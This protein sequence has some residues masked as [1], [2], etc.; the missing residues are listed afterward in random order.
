[1][2][3]VKLAAGFLVA[4]V[5]VSNAAV[6][7]QPAA[8]AA[9]AATGKVVNAASCSQADVQKATDSASDG[10]SVV[11]P[12][13]SG[14]W[15]TPVIIANKGITLR[16]AGINKTVITA[17]TGHQQCPL[18]VA[19]VEGKPLRITGFTFNGTRS[20]G[21]TINLRGTCK[22]FRVDHC[23]ISN[24]PSQ[25][26]N[27]RG[28][29]AGGYSYGVIDH[30]VIVVPEPGGAPY[31][32]V[33]FVGDGDAAWERPITLGTA[34]AAYV[35]DC[36]FYY[37][38]SFADG[39]LDAYGG[40]RYVFRHNTVINTMVGHHGLDSGGYR[41]PHSF[42]YYENTFI[43]DP[44]IYHWATFHFRGGTGVVFNNTMTGY[45]AAILVTNYRSMRSYDPWGK[46]DGKNPIDGNEDPSGYP[47][48]DQIGRTTGQK[49]DPLC[50]WNN[51]LGGKHM[52]IGL[53]MGG[54]DHPELLQHIKE[55]RDYYNNTVKPGY[56]PYAYPHPLTLEPAERAQA[57]EPSPAPTLDTKPE[58]TAA[59]REARMLL[60][61]GE[62][63][64][65]QQE[66]GTAKVLF[67]ELVK[68]HPGTK[69]AE[70]ATEHLGRMK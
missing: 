57:P 13:G 68:R 35:E 55:N 25:A 14:T 50:E 69:Y 17:A 42:E 39:A 36:I 66:P 47:A 23:K 31:Q 61:H 18:A 45:G 33:S 22:D 51:I 48:K 37:V 9:Q 15:A 53:N 44:T 41:S 70:Q 20:I 52:D 8:A 40:A 11:V 16:G 2:F 65:R 62:F 43:T 46:C 27:G 21:G 5:V 28:V 29:M 67:N 4:T 59:E 30:C 34:N 49:L 54:E 32:A 60:S 10:D 12:A 3:W 63:L 56:T 64:L 58:L 1:M 7:E 26:E 19:G 38:N 24:T 6:A